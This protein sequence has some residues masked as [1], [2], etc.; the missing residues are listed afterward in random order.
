[1]TWSYFVVA[2]FRSSESEPVGEAEGIDVGARDRNGTCIGARLALGVLLR[3]GGGGCRGRGLF[4]RLG[5]FACL[6]RRRSGG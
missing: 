1:M 6:R 3:D 4:A 5:V 2:V